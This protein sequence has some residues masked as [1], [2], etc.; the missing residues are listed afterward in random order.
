MGTLNGLFGMPDQDDGGLFGAIGSLLG[1]AKLTAEQQRGMRAATSRILEMSGPSRTPRTFMQALGSGM[2]AFDD[3]VQSARDRAV[4]EQQRALQQQLLDWK[5]K[6]AEADYGHQQKG[7]EREDRI[8]KRTAA[9]WGAGGLP[10]GFDAG[11]GPGADNFASNAGDGMAAPGLPPRAGGVMNPAGLTPASHMNGSEFTAAAARAGLPD[12]MGTLNRI[13]ALVNRGMTPDQAAASISGKSTAP[14]Q[15]RDTPPQQGRNDFAPPPQQRS[16]G[17]MSELG[18]PT[19]GS[20]E[21]MQGIQQQME[22]APPAQSGAPEWMQSFNK[23]TSLGL[24]TS[25]ALSTAMSQREPGMQSPGGP[26]KRPNQTQMMVQNLMA[27]ARIRFEE[28]DKPGAEKLLEMAQKFRPKAT[29]KEVTQGNR[30]VNQAFFDDGEEGEMSNSAVAA[31][32]H[33][34]NVGPHTKGVDAYTGEERVRYQNG[35]SPSDQVSIQNSMRSDRRARDANDIAAGRKV[36][37]TSTGLRKEFDDLPEVKSY[38][39]AL[40]A[41]SAIEGAVK[42]NTTQSD[43]NIVYGL[44]KLYDP[45]SVVREG[46]Y[47]TVANS[48]NVPERVKGW[49]QYVAG[50]GRLTQQVK[51]EIMAEAKG[52]MKSYEDPYMSARQNYTTISRNSGA[53]PSLIFPSEHRSPTTTRKGPTHKS[54]MKGQVM[55]GYRFKGGNPADPNAWEKL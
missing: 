18:M 48:P 45:D 30:V 20:P 21:W 44:A 23:L 50:G 31:K 10:G 46:E 12:D 43:I 54:A 24:P 19:I 11:M 49:I 16:A 51:N 5:I 26:G 27:E 55:D 28:G 52:R 3:G 22:S 33:F 15:Q 37:D 4:L 25:V 39:K 14:E 36:I 13:V 42:R 40:P 35:L 38:K 8:S 7:R 32:L 9:V 41:F 2:G 47:A 1:G 17:G 53:D 34:Q 29:W 6:D